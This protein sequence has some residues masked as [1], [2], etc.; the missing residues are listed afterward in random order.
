MRPFDYARASSAQDAL[1]LAAARP[2]AAFIAG[3]TD[4]LP[5]WKDAV[6]V[7]PAVIDISRLQLDG[8]DVHDRGIA[9]GALVRMADV[10]DHP[11]MRSEYPAIAE[12]LLA[13]ASPQLR[14][15][16]TIGGNL[17]QRTRCGYFRNV[18]FPCNKRSAGSGCAALGGDDRRHAIFG[19]SEHCAA[20]HASDLA[21]ALVALDATVELRGPSGDRVVAIEQLF[22]V[23]GDR[24]D[25]ETALLPGELIA[26]IRV[27]RTALARRSHYLKVR[28][29][30][31]FDFAV[32]SV[33][34][35]L[36]IEDGEVRE[37][38]VAAGGVGT[39]PWRLHSSER[40]LA[41]EPAGDRAFSAA[42]A[43]ASDGA[44]PLR[45][46]GFKLELLRRCVRRALADLAGGA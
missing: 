25:R 37:A 45:H 42:A 5:L 23:P 11:A 28:D 27:P 31:S 29:R 43:R 33:A 38:R 3:G 6:S 32:V 30:A 41:G 26:A 46:N 34:V 44:R 39:V 4:L 8:I 20:T 19:A 18:G 15:A 10:A 13:S 16:A 24:P 35:A 21:V 12:A 1:D 17:L 36:D 14:N 9:I 7:P 40:A 2:G 22:V